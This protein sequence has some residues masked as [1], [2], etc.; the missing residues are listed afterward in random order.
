MQRSGWGWVAICLVALALSWPTETAQAQVN[1]IG[2]AATGEDA[3]TDLTDTVFSQPNREVLRHLSIGR[4][5]LESGR[6]SEAVGYLQRI[7][8]GAEDY[9]FQPDKSSAVRLS[10]KREAERLVAQ[11]RAHGWTGTPVISG[12]DDSGTCP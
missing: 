1:I 3:S 12:N 5:L 9:F 8:D 6:V 4:Q 7:L 10:L 11:L 2:R